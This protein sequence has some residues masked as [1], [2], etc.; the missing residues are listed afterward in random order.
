MFI[1]GRFAHGFRQYWDSLKWFSIPASLGFAYIC[2]QQYGHIRKREQR[3]LLESDPEQYLAK[4]WQ[5]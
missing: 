3:K 1:S 4:N 2:Y 5:V